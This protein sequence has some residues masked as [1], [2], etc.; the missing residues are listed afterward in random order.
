MK[1]GLGQ[2]NELTDDILT[3]IKQIGVDDFQ[4]NF[5]HCPL[6]DDGYLHYEDLQSLR[7]RG[8]AHEYYVYEGEGHG[9][10]RPET[11]AAFYRAVEGFL[12]QYVLF[13]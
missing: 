11:I 12:K 4:M 6:C 7:Q 13:T 3:F 5:Y 10:R 2:F 9:W 1:I 8:V